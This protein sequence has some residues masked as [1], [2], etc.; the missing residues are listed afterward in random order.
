MTMNVMS[1]IPFW[2]SAIL[3]L[4]SVAS[5]IWVGSQ[6]AMFFGVSF[7]EREIVISLEPVA[8]W[9]L[10]SYAFLVIFFLW[11]AGHA[12]SPVQE[13]LK[14]LIKGEQSLLFYLGVVVMGLAIPIAITI[15]ALAGNGSPYLSLLILRVICAVLGDMILRY[16]ITKSGRYSPLIY[17]NIVK[18]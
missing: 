18:G 14:V 16:V 6:L 1:S 13:S 4:L 11:N 5:G 10:F 2:N 3:P 12:A 15:G 9:S 17:S 7:S 8:R